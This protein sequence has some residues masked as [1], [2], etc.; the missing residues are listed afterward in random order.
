VYGTPIQDENFEEFVAMTMPIVGGTGSIAVATLTTDAQSAIRTI[1]SFG[2]R[3]RLQVSDSDPI[4][5]VIMHL[6]GT[7]KLLP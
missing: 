6:Q 7:A 5:I 4:E 1:P 2:S 3:L